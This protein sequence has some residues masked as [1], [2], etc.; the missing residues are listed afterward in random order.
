MNAEATAKNRRLLEAMNSGASLSRL[1]PGYMTGG[2]V[3]PSYQAQRPVMPPASNESTAR[4]KSSAASSSRK[5]E[6]H[7][8]ITASDAN[9]FV[10]SEGQVAAAT[11][12]AIERGSR[13]L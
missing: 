2:Y 8:N 6:V 7:L 13:N 12:R 10:K 1:V 5:V 9:S 3:E 11:A 4:G